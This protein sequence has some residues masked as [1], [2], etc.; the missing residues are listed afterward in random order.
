M[1]TWVLI[2][3]TAVG[4]ETMELPSQDECYNTWTFVK[5]QALRNQI[6]VKLHC[7][8]KPKS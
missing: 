6:E 3:L 2:I 1:S 4:V 8:E 7:M 5:D